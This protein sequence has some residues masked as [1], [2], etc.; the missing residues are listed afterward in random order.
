MRLRLF[1]SMAA[2]IIALGCTWLAYPAVAQQ[3]KPILI[4]VN[5][6]IQL[7]VGRDAIDAPK[8]AIDEINT[9]GGV[10]G[11]KLDIVV[12][13]EA[14]RNRRPKGRRRGQQADRRG[15]CRRADRRLRQRRDAGGAAA[16]RRAPRRSSSASARPR[17]RSQR[18]SR[19]TTS[20]T[21]TFS[22]ST[23]SIRRTRRTNSSSFI[24][25]KLKGDL[26]YNKISIIGE[27]AK[28]VQDMVPALKK[29]AEDAGLEV[30]VARVLRSRR[31]RT[32]RRSSPR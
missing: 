13:D 17:P 6:A 12:A 27:N 10:L 29:G 30:P 31:R 28:W 19:T 20:T 3:D 9:R 4:G 32:S 26:G 18:R 5:T 22:A 16:Y 8:L 15:S 23:R 1:S 25:G 21:N 14:R 24:T 7:Q 2:T 11:R